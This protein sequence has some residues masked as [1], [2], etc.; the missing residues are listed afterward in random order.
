MATKTAV[1]CCDLQNGILPF[2]DEKDQTEIFSKAQ[3]T[4]TAS[5]S[6]GF[7]VVYIR[8]VFRPNYPEINPNNQVIE[9]I[10]FKAFFKQKITLGICCSQEYWKIY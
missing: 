8:V 1:L 10:F 2:L 5:R 7:L 6:K 9:K 3:K 4:L